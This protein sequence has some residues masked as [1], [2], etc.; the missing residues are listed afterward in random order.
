M[1]QINS[2][3]VLILSVPL[4]ILISIT[5]I[6]GLMYPEMYIHETINWQVQ[7]YGQDLSDLFLAV[8]FLIV[9]SA[10]A[11]RRNAAGFLLWG[12]TNLYL[13]YTFAIYCFDIH[14][15]IL[16]LLYC[17]ILGLS[18]Y[19]FT[20][21]LLS[22]YKQP[23]QE[24]IYKTPP[25]RATA[26][27]LLIVAFLFYFLWL[28]GIL[29]SILH[30]TT[31]KDLVE[32]G[33]A[34]NPVHVLDLSALLPA[35]I[36][37]AILI[38]RKKAL[39]LYVAPALLTFCLLMDITIGLLTIIMYLKKVGAGYSVA[40]IMGI[41]ALISLLLMIFYIKALSQSDPAKSV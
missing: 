5:S 8:P 12:G 7:S 23:A 17:T 11:Y 25:V 15:N 32:I 31:P 9:T 13:T 36:I 20:Y 27:Y 2:K 34:T 26:Y 19:S 14:F 28:S 29:P 37:T 10:L 39:G 22:V 38:I 6:A 40:L 24:E 41:F 35:F 33:L 16:F 1:M 21:F 30:N 3:L 18:V 4:A